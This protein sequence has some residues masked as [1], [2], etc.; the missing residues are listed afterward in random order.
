M[1]QHPCA[2][3]D[4]LSWACYHD[5]RKASSN[6]TV[7]EDQFPKY[8]Q[9]YCTQESLLAPRK[10]SSVNHGPTL[11]EAIQFTTRKPISLQH[12]TNTVYHQVTTQNPVPKATATNQW[13]LIRFFVISSLILTGK[14]VL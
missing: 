6:P 4:H 13:I 10:T 3:P 2:T 8:M 9:D 7:K 5:P 11:P 14:F 12:S 1:D